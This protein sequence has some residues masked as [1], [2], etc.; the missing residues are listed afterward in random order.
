MKFRFGESEVLVNVANRA[1]LLSAVTARLAARHGF[2]L[3]T[4][5]LDHLVKLRNSDKFRRAYA[6][7]DLIVADGPFTDTDSITSG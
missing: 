2:A 4:I 3:A 1:A 5:N 6:A 7:Q